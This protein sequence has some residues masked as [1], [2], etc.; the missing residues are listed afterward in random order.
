MGEFHCVSLVLQEFSAEER[1]PVKI[2]EG[3]GVMFTCS[4]PPHYPGKGSH[5]P[6][7]GG[8]GNA[9]PRASLLDFLWECQGSKPGMNSL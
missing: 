3:W 1:E 2:A 5:P 4:P 9:Q 6:A 7:A 8:G